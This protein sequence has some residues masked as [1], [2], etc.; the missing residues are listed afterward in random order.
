MV[1]GGSNVPTCASMNAWICMLVVAGGAPG[2]VSQALLVLHTWLSEQSALVRHWMQT[3]DAPE[4]S[5][6]GFVASTELQLSSMR[7]ALHRPR[8]LL[9]VASQ[10]SVLP[11]A[12]AHSVSLVQPQKLVAVSQV[13]RVPGQCVS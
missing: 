6:K 3:G 4:V 13:G 9:A 11:G 1:S 12:A 5:Q 10:K 2:T 7:H 8:P